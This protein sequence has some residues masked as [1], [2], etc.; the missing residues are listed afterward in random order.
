MVAFEDDGA[1]DLL[2]KRTP[3]DS[4]AGSVRHG[5]R[6]FCLS[7]QQRGPRLKPCDAASANSLKGSALMWVKRSA[8][9]LCAARLAGDSWPQRS[10]S[11]LLRVAGFLRRWSIGWKLVK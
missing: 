1:Q 8:A 6:Q 5:E 2:V 3:A 10:I 4:K 11:G 9:G 7:L